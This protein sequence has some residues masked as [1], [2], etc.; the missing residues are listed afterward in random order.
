MVEGDED[1]DNV[2]RVKDCDSDSDDGDFLDQKNE[3][4]I[5]KEIE[6]N[7]NLSKLAP[8]FQKLEELNTYIQNI[9][10]DH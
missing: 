1:K 6:N 3:I 7:E 9:Q 4:P 10:E 2:F 8:S 5:I